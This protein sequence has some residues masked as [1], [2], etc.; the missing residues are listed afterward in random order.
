MMPSWVLASFVAWLLP[1]YPAWSDDWASIRSA[2]RQIT[3]V[4]ADFV[5]TKHLKMLARPIASEGKFFYRRPG[6]IRWEYST[7]IKSV[8]IS[9]KQGVRRVTWRDGRYRADTD[10]KLKPLQTVLG[11]ME[12]WLRGDF[13][14]SAEFVPKL[15]P[16]PPA[17]VKLVPRDKGLG[18]FIS[19]VYVVLSETPGV[20]DTI[21]IWEGPGAVTRLKLKSV[22]LNQPLTARVFRPPA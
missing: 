13:D 7:P 22:K 20:V 15:E 17:R 10:A 1:V 8:L 5:Q 14:Q 18:Q 16:G 12:L 4:Q 21:E 2:A 9:N 19:V 6:E 3:T 11:Q